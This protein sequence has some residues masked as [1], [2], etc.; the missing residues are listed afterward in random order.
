MKIAVPTSGGVLSPHFGHC[1]QFTIIEVDME[2]K[3]VVATE[4]LD[5]PPHEPGALPP[6][7]AG[8]G[9]NMVIAGGMGQR[10]KMMFEQNGIGVVVGA[11]QETPEALVKCLLDDRLVDGR[12]LCD[13][14]N[15]G[16]CDHAEEHD[17]TRHSDR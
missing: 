17:R 2:A 9:C 4:A 10:A 11:P 12:N 6:W 15:P 1:E 13:H 16:D 7:L 8:L 5:A 14:S 3:E